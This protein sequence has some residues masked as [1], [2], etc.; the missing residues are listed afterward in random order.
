MAPPSINAN[1]EDSACLS[2]SNAKGVHTFNSRRTKEVTAYGGLLELP[3]EANARKGHKR[4]KWKYP[5][6]SV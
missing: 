5:V 4:N 3:Q 1:L 2:R 6:N